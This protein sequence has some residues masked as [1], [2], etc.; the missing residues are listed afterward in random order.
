[1]LNNENTIRSLPEK[2]DYFI[3]K[4]HTKISDD[5]L[6]VKLSE[7][8]SMGREILRDIKA[9]MEHLQN[10]KDRLDQDNEKQ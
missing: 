9:T 5:N 3:E 10:I 4:C 6:P 7:A 1:M 2:F 8:L